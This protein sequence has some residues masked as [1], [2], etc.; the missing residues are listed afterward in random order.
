MVVV[1]VLFE[2]YKLNHVRVERCINFLKKNPEVVLITNIKDLGLGRY[3][4]TDKKGFIDYVLI[5]QYLSEFKPE[6][7]TYIDNDLILCEDYF[8][9]L[10]IENDVPRIMHGFSFCNEHSDRKRTVPSV[11]MNCVDNNKFFGHSGYCWT[12]NQK[13][14]QLMDYKFPEFF[15]IGGFDYFLA[16]CIKSNFKKLFD[17][18]E[19]IGWYNTFHQAK[20]SYYPVVIYHLYH[21]PQADRLTPFDHYFTTS[22]EDFMITI[23]SQDNYFIA[24]N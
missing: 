23:N 6:S 1:T 20:W 14:L 9:N 18:P 4:Y 19:L 7:L 12:F 22:V 16:S 17:H 10:K 5:N 21:G 11:V 24:N 13:M 15:L 8:K 3:Y 2:S